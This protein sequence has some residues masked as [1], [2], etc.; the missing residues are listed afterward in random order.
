MNSLIYFN[1]CASTQDELIDFLNQHYLSEDFLAVYTF[2][3]TKGR[4]QYG[5]SWENLPEENLA[6]SFALKTKNI[7]ISDTCFNF[8]TAILVRDFIANLTKT[9]VKIKW[10]NDLILKNKKI[11]GMLFEKNKNYFVVGIGINI[12]QENFKNLP[13]AGSVLSQTGL[14]FELKAFAESLHQYLFEYLVQ[15]EIPNDVL[16][17][18]HLHLYR[19]NE[20]S[21]FEKNE[22]RQNGII[23]NVDENGYIWIDLENEGLQKFFHKEIELLY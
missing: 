19:K 6:Y 23:Q 9:E 7:N 22:I 1:N 21:V 20:V 11:C 13:K 14:S 5:N 10:P 18:Y 8:Y 12:L 2:N 4:G 3:Q 15:K 17:L 16:E